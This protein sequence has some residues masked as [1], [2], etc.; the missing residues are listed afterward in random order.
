MNP[1]KVNRDKLHQLTDLPNVGKAVADDLRKLGIHRP[2][3]LLGRDAYAMYY[4][5]CEI[6]GT[7]HDPCMMDVFLSLTDFMQGN[8]AQPWWAFTARRK[9][10]LLKLG[11]K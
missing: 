4:E 10:Y 5:L 3:D 6:T 2:Q 9:A 8:E 7:Q 1:A 11:H